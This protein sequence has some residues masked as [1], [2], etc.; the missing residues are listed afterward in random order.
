M[1][2][3][4][5]RWPGIETLLTPNQEILIADSADQVTEILAHI[6][7]ERRRSIA[8][9]ARRRVLRNHTADHRAR[10]LED[11]YQEVLDR[12]RAKRRVEAVA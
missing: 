4:S 5:D 1:P 7:E 6:P 9:A 3:I 11:Y 10:A 8:A 12:D 2:I